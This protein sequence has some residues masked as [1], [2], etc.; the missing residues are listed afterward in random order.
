MSQSSNR[1]LL[2]VLPPCKQEG[3]DPAN[4]GTRKHRFPSHY[5]YSHIS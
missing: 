3:A 2:K 1:M 5:H 4:K